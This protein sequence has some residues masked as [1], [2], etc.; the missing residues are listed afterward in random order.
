MNR[1]EVDALR[2]GVTVAI[3]RQLGVA[4]LLVGLG[5]L[6]LVAELDTR[7]EEALELVEHRGPV[8]CIGD[9]GAGRV[10]VLWST[11]LCC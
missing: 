1:K 4:H 6:L 7:V 5:V 8:V 9:D 2:K 3:V 11:E 10:L